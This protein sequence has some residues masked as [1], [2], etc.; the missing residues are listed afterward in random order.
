MEPFSHDMHVPCHDIITLPR[1]T[2]SMYGKDHTSNQF[3]QCI[4]QDTAPA[5]E[6]AH[7]RICES[8]SGSPFPSRV[9]YHHSES[10][11]SQA[12]YVFF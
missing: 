6:Q 3:P 9:A 8:H 5:G 7:R 11:R 1:S 4:R 2:A 10:V 12:F